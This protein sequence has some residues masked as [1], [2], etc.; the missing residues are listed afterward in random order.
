[1]ENKAF[2]FTTSK[3]SKEL[4]TLKVEVDRNRLGEEIK[5]QLVHYKPRV[6]IKGFRVGH[7]P[8]DIILSRYKEELKAAAE[9]T[10]IEEAWNNYQDA[11]KVFALGSPKVV[12]I[13]RENEA[14]QITYEYYQMPEVSSIDVAK[15]NL[16]KNIYKVDD[17]TVEN[18][19]KMYIKRF[20]QFV[21]TEDKIVIDDKVMVS[22]EFKSDNQKKYN[23]E[24]SVMATDNKEE[25]IFAL[26][27]VGMKKGE[28]KTLKTFINDE[29]ATLEM[30][31][32][33]VERP[34]MKDDSKEEDRQK[35][36]DSLKEH[37]AEKA[38]QKGDSDLINKSIY[39]KLVSEVKV[40][41]PKGYLEEQIESSVKDLESSLLRQNT[42]LTDYLMATSKTKSELVKEYA[43]SVKKQITFDLA[44]AKIIEEHKDTITVDENKANEYANR[45][46][47]YQS[48][49]GLTKMSKEDQQQVVRNIMR[50]AQNKATSEAV[51]DYIKANAS[52]KENGETSY[53]PTD[54]DLWMGMGGGY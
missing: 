52:I 45:M 10:L 30:T 21:E 9:E 12:K 51:L 11:N 4:T 34:D 40:S 32:L 5:K 48:Y 24:F 39:E 29:E 46:Y 54:Q 38:K 7:A 50:E 13:D 8:D 26:G 31:I 17:N 27:V 1:M 16:E 6:S 36:K 22:I 28:K 53:M 49:M 37:L 41:I 2:T 23:R 25:S 43:E 3:D 14:L 19:Y 20:S 15:L 35:V 42:T 18:A 44:L 47:Q 33:K